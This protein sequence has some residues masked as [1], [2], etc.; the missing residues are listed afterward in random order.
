MSQEAALREPVSLILS[1][2]N[3]SSSL[4]F[5]CICINTTDD[6]MVIMSLHEE[7]DFGLVFFLEE[8]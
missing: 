8:G 2:P 3:H 5:I 1:R 4:I 7:I 6:C